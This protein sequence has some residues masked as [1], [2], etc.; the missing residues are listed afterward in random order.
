MELGNRVR[1]GHC[2]GQDT[3]PKVPWRDVVSK[4]CLEKVILK[5]FFADVTNYGL[6]WEGRTRNKNTMELIS[7]LFFKMKPFLIDL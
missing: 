7:V 4:V 3:T 2:L 5:C 1:A 6:S